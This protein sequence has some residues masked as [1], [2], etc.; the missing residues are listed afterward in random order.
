[1]RKPLSPTMKGLLRQRDRLLIKEAYSILNEY[2][3]IKPS[4]KAREK[5]SFLQQPHGKQFDAIFNAESR[6]LT[7]KRGPF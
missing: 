7:F 3:P 6:L 1:M 4:R 2:P 5:C